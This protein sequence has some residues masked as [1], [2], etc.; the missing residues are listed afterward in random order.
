MWKQGA[1]AVRNAACIENE[2]NVIAQRATK[3]CAMTSESQPAASVE[4]REDVA[5][6]V[7]LLGE[8]EAE[9][10]TLKDENAR[11]W[12]SHDQLK[13]ELALLKRRIFVAKAEESRHTGHGEDAAHHGRT[14][15]A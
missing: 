13:E 10:A 5:T 2:R 11:L 1:R 8:R 4:G 6:R 12:R 3:A 15:L 14:R 9:I 7:S